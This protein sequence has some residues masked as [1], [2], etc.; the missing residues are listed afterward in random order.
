M[1]LQRNK[2]QPDQRP[3]TTLAISEGAVTPFT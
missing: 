3:L 2:M 1:H